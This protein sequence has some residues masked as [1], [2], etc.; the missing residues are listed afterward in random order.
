MPQTVKAPAAAMSVMMAKA[1]P[2]ALSRMTK[3]PVVKSQVARNQVV[4]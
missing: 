4:S 1:R 2:E 3:T